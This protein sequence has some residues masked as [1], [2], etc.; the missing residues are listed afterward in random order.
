M[1][2][3]CSLIL[4]LCRHLMTEMNPQLLGA[5]SIIRAFSQWLCQRS[6]ISVPLVGALRREKEMKEA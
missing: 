4:F 3:A 6:I 1:G 5:C 2:N